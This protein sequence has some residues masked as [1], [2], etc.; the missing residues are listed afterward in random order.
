[1]RSRRLP[2]LSY[3]IIFY[4][5]VNELSDAQ[6][7]ISLSHQRHMNITLSLIQNRQHLHCKYH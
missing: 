3:F 6:S 4:W 1:M 5:Y 7:F 2:A